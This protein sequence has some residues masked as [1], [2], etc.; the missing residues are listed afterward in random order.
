MPIGDSD[1]RSQEVTVAL[2]SLSKARLKLWLKVLRVSR[3]VLAELRDRFKK[4][5]ASTLP[6]FDVMAAL[7]RSQDGLKMNELSSLLRVSNGNVTG[8]VERLVE[9]GTVVR[10]GV[11]GDRRAF[12][13]KLTSVGKKEFA[14]Q[15]KAHEEWVSELFGLVS[16][17]DAKILA[18]E[19]DLMID[20]VTKEEGNC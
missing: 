19:L 16:D 15:A 12:I 11:P 13:V 10:L 3:V 2:P 18:D 6:R 4:E 9:D 14:V 1:N 5:F 17:K 7:D 20:S 8:I